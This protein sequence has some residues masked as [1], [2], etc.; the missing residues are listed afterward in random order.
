[1]TRL[2]LRA[3]S[4]ADLAVLSGMVQDA[5]LIRTDMVYLAAE[6]RFVLAINRFCWEHP[7]EPALRVSAGLVFD[8]VN[9]VRVRGLAQDGFL[10]LLAAQAVGDEIRLDFSGGGAVLLTVGR[11]EARLEDFG[12]PWPTQWRPRHDLD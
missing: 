2:R 9:R 5:V 6:R 8:A 11:I 4:A 12:E 1:M 3:V 10:A 7:A